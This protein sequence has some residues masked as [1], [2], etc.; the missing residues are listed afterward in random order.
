MYWFTQLLIRY[1]FL[2]S[3]EIFSVSTSAKLKS[4]ARYS[5]RDLINTVPKKR[6][7]K[8]LGEQGCHKG[9]FRFLNGFGRPVKKPFICDITQSRMHVREKW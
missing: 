7:E 3:T 6:R 8:W 5:L 4:S 1:A 2:K 9:I